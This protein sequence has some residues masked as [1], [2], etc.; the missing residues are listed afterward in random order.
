MD[1]LGPLLNRLRNFLSEPAEELG[2][3]RRMLHYSA[4]LAVYCYRK[5]I[6]DRASQMAAALTYRT[7]F[8]LLP[9]LALALVVL[10][11]FRGLEQY[12]EQFKS[13]VVEFLLPETLLAAEI[14]EAA[15]SSSARAEFRALDGPA[16]AAKSDSDT[17]RESNAEIQA[18]DDA[19]QQLGERIGGIIDQLSHIN[20]RGIGVVGVLIFL[21]AA[22]ALL[23]TIE[24]SFNSV[25]GV[26][27]ARPWYL[28]LTFYYTVI[29]LGPIVLIAGQ[30]LQQGA[31][32]ALK[33]GAWVNWLAVPLVTLSPLL[34]TWLVLA[35]MFVLLPHT[36][37]NKRPALVGSLVAAVLWVATKELFAVYVSRAGVTNLYGALGL[38]PLFLM[39][40]YLTWLIVLFGLELTATLQGMRSGRFRRQLRSE[41]PEAESV[42]NPQWLVPV[43]IRMARL[44]SEGHIAAA[45]ELGDQLG[46]PGSAAGRLLA[47]LEKRDL[48]HRVHRA[49][50]EG[51]A[52]ARPADTIAVRHL[53]DLAGELG[54]ARGTAAGG[55]EWDYLGRLSAAMKDAAGEATLADLVVETDQPNQK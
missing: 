14:E 23:A 30:V 49:D 25:F 38:V 28:R 50:D 45:S 43:M 26:E 55:R 19:R 41:P 17:A 24:R 48:V 20:F 9:M 33:E 46:L 42:G 54:R 35:A 51:Y 18:L 32:D 12:H 16:D 2:R 22:T 27:Q 31:F 7:L 47:W 15:T 34:T 21:Y 52:L 36:H 4:R 3:T 37:V 1:I 11:G 13:S 8:S 10:G 29:T 5:L 39:W 44:F 40:L 53:I 6:Q